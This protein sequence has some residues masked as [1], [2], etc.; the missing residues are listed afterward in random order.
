M[1]FSGQIDYVLSTPSMGM[2]SLGGQFFY[3]FCMLT[4]TKFCPETDHGKRTIS[5]GLSAISTHVVRL[6]QDDSVWIG[7]SL[8]G[9]C[10]LTKCPS[11]NSCLFFPMKAPC[12]LWGCKYR[13][14]PFPGRMSYKATKPGLVFV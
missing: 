1:T 6:Q 3:L 7:L 2:G 11:R 4:A 14:A 5:S 9:I 12:G 13:P 10:A 8:S